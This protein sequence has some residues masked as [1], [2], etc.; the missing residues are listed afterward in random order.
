MEV[1]VAAVVEMVGAVLTSGVLL[2]VCCPIIGSV[3]DML[4]VGD[5]ENN[6]GECS[7]DAIY[8]GRVV[9]SSTGMVVG[10]L[11]VVT[12]S[13]FVCTFPC[14]ISVMSALT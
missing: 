2:C 12:V 10:D 7:F 11:V 9:D 13:R 6:L 3:L 1:A 14:L 4:N 8:G 5:G